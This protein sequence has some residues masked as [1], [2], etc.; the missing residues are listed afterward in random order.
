VVLQRGRTPH[1]EAKSWW[2]TQSASYLLVISPIRDPR[3]SCHDSKCTRPRIR[4]DSTS[5]SAPR[6]A[7]FKANNE[8]V[9]CLG[10]RWLV[11]P[12]WSAWCRITLT[13]GY[14]ISLKPIGNRKDPASC[15]NGHA[16][17][18]QNP[19]ALPPHPPNCPLAGWSR[20][21]FPS[22]RQACSA[23]A[24]WRPDSLLA[25]AG[26]ASVPT[27]GGEFFFFLAQRRFV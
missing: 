9:H 22:P 4:R 11:A 3:L 18:Y 5:R 26:S 13:R 24:A 25:T 8:Q 20:R 14:I 12:I 7:F 16:D 23:L 19:T 6:W 1:A 21:S 2:V 17:L 15:N 10:H 27:A